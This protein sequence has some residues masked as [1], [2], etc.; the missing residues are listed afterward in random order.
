MKCLV[1]GVTGQS[2]SYLAE[3]LVRRGDEVY[4]IKRRTSTNNTQNL[5]NLLKIPQFKLIEG[6]V[7][8][9]SFITELV[10]DGQFEEIY[11][12]AAQ[13]NVGTSFNIP[14]ATTS[15]I[16][17]AT[18]YLLE[19]IRKY[20]IHTRFYF[21]G[22]SE[23]FGSNYSTTVNG[24]KYQDENTPFKPRSPYSVAKL[25]GFHLT[26]LYR[27]AYGLF[28]CSGILFNHESPRRSP[29]FVTRKI[30]QYVAYLKR[31]FNCATA[32]NPLKKLSLGNIY[33]YRDF[34]YAPDYTRAMQLMLKQDSPDDFVIATGETN[35]IQDVLDE[36]FDYINLSKYMQ[37]CVIIDDTLKR[38]A[39]VDYLC[40]DSSKARDILGWKPTV[41]FQQ[42]IRK[43]IDND[44]SQPLW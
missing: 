12:L 20:S 18:L 6:D 11:S 10:L 15:S 13:S 42:L 27:E 32:T 9:A 26:R 8:D 35:S 34:G 40:G 30:S 33:A 41:N 29:Q 3:Q 38:P 21:S 16:Y 19:A 24:I 25:A 14:Q 37:D 1:T 44:L 5:T 31:T 22:S 39:E 43:M 2:G 36:A 28:A 7:T 4:G 23:M 17:D